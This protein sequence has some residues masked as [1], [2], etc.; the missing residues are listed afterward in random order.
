MRPTKKPAVFVAATALGI[1]L[2]GCA[3]DAG[4]ASDTTVASQPAPA[5]SSTT[6]AAP[7]ADVTAD[8][9]TSETPAAQAPAA[10]A[11]IDQAT[12]EANKQQYHDAGDVVLFFNAS[13]C[14]TCQQTVANLDA[15]GVPPGVTVVSV[16]YDS[17]SELKQEYGVTVQHTF[18]QV[19][20][21][22][23]QQAKFTGALTGEQISSKTV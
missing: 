7:P 13:W 15:D 18:V 20:E 23:A 1:V 3:S 5:A 21:S 14:P 19:D 17:A 2:A 16:D 10:G 9:A 4:E 8:A 22:G 12:Y 11:W 6:A